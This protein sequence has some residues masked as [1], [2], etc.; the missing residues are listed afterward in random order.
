MYQRARRFAALAA[1][2]PPNDLSQFL[3]LAEQQ[4][5][6]YLVA[7]NAL[8]LVDS[9]VGAYIVL[10]V[11]ADEPSSH[12]SGMVSQAR[13]RRK[14]T[15]HIPENRFAGGKRDSEFIG[16]QD[17]KE[18]YALL[19]AKVELIKREPGLLGASGKICFWVVIFRGK[20]VDGFF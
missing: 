13:K 20:W 3:F 6:A 1:S 16:L 5:D 18:E 19:N 15:K 8:A 4:L 7:I 12:L 10:P 17:V 11:N 9:K 2:V 14:L